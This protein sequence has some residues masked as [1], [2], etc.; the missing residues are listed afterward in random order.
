M[1]GIIFS[2]VL[3]VILV[4]VE[5]KSDELIKQIL[6]QESKHLSKACEHFTIIDKNVNSGS[7]DF[8]KQDV[9]AFEEHVA[10]GK[11]LS[12][13]ADEKTKMLVEKIN[14]LAETNIYKST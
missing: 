11:S 7:F 14:R 4:P 5:L 2:V 13:T 8:L 1:L 6:D 9:V 10:S 3:I 12:C